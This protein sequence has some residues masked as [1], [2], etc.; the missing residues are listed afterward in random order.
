MFPYIHIGKQTLPMFSI[1]AALGAL[2]AIGVFFLLTKKLGIKNKERDNLILLFPVIVLGGIFGAMIYD[3][4]AH[5]GETPWYQP[6]GLAFSGGLIGGGILFFALYPK[7]MKKEN[8]DLKKHLNLFTP[9][10][11]IAHCF[12]RIGCF[13][14]GCCFGR[15]TDSF[16]GVMFPEGSIAHEQLGHAAYVY[17]TQLFE[18]AFLLLLFAVLLFL[19]IKNKSKYNFCIY[20]VSYG[21]WRFFIEFLRGDNRGNVSDILSPSQL[22]SIIIVAAGVAAFF[23]FKKYGSN[24]VAKNEE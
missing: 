22:L 13:L 1:M 23:I 19:A 3:K 14:A 6:A 21:V 18:A 12:G 2:A 10:L 20:L 4:I 5:W 17:P 8:R 16:L 24:T 15:E 11:V 7:I 9:C